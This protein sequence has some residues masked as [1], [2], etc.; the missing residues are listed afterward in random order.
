MQ[1]SK[2]NILLAKENADTVQQCN[3]EYLKYIHLIIWQGALWKQG[4]TPVTA[5][6]TLGIDCSQETMNS[7]VNEKD[8]K[9]VH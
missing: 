3:S 5:A 9:V 7:K 1:Q 2:W 8:T 4:A 6:P